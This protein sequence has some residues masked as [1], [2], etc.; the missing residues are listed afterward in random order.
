MK[1]INLHCADYIDGHRRPE[2]LTICVDLPL[3]THYAETLCDLL[4]LFRADAFALTNALVDALPQGTMH[5]L[6]ICLLQHYPS[7]FVG[8]TPLREE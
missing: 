3:N 5:A 7:Y 8:T 4:T 1:V 6:L 2:H